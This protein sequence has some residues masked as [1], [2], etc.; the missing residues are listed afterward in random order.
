MPAAESRCRP[1]RR[2][3]PPTLATLAAAAGLAALLAACQAAPPQS[4]AA[5]DAA[6][7]AA[8][9]EAA[10]LARIAAEVGDAPC[11]EDAQCHTLALGARP[12][13]GP[14]RWLPWSSAQGRVPQLQ[15]WAD[16]LA[17][18]QRARQARE[19]LAGDCRHLPDPGAVCRAGHCV[20]AGTGADAPS[21]PR[22][23]GAVAR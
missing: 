3:S 21:A 19:G 8:P 7:G 13:G 5:P 16:E 17:R 23:G 12:C 2:R 18:L 11:Q 4:T 14:Q 22:A 1:V 9:G 15:A 6:P 10:L 20:L